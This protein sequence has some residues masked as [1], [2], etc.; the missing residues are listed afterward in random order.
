M[1]VGGEEQPESHLEEV[2]SS[3]SDVL[4]QRPGKTSEGFIF[5]KDVCS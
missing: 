2:H 3:S 1:C 4:L 5:S